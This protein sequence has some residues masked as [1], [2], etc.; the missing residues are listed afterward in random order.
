M[1][2]KFELTLEI[3]WK[4]RDNCEKGKHKLRDNNFGITWCIVCG[5]LSNKPSNIPFQKHEQITI[6]RLK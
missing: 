3:Y 6:N 5:L 2:N 1:D 4:W